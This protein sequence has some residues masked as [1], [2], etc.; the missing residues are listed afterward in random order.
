M[1]IKKHLFPI[2]ITFR[3]SPSFDVSSQK[4]TFRITKYLCIRLS[5]V[6]Y[7]SLKNLQEGAILC[8]HEK[9]PI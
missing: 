8:P 9:L 2:I 7:F 6:R 3:D 1:I 5:S 4:I